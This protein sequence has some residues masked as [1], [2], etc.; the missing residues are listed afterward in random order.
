LSGLESGNVSEL[1]GN[2]DT[3]SIFAS[4]NSIHWQSNELAVMSR[5]FRTEV[6]VEGRPGGTGISIKEDY[7]GVAGG[8][9]GGLVGGLGLGVGF[10]VGFG[11]GIGALGSALFS[12]AVPVLCLGGLF[13]LADSIYKRFLRMRREKLEHVA[14]DI[15]HRL[16]ESGT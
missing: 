6:A 15:S 12:V 5:G 2:H 9:Y 3:V 16:E 1:S 8:L 11:V 10:G 7:H 4:Q 14:S 13:L